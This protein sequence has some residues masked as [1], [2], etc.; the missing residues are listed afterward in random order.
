M[1]VE[2]HAYI[3]HAKLGIYRELLAELTFRYKKVYSLSQEPS[4]KYQY[5]M[6]VCR[7]FFPPFLPNWKM[8]FPTLV[9]QISVRICKNNHVGNKQ[10][11]LSVLIE[12]I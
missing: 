8:T 1:Q 9:A 7:I 6:T 11:N 2:V 4:K 10:I 12:H 3:L 5:N